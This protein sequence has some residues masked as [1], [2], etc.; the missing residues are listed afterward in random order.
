VQTLA[1]RRVLVTGGGAGI[2]KAIARR[3]AADGAEVLLADVNAAAGEQAAHELRGTGGKARAYALD[4]TDKDAVRA[5]HARILEEAGPVDVLVNN[6]GLVF[7]GPFLDVPLERHLLTYTVN[8]LGMVA[9]THAFLPDLL[10]SSDAHV[11]NIASASAYVGLPM[12]ATYASSKWAVLGFSESLELELRLQGHRHVH[13][14]TA[15]PSYVSTGLFD[16]ARPPLFTRLLT[17][18]RLAERVRN[19]VVANRRFVRT[20]WLVAVTPFLKGTLPF[21]VF[22]AIA[23]RLGVSTSMVAW[24]GHKRA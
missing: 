14:T 16:G 15:C 5:L 1:G 3:F 10:A 2:G 9:V 12:G 8:V 4:V 23:S 18:E 13:V 7:G 19:A 22:Y 24:R 6:A 11:V 20:P 21:G 17:A